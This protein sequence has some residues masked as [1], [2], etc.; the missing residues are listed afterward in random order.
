MSI[1]ERRSDPRTLMIASVVGGWLVGLFLPTDVFQLGL[2]LV[3][4]LFELH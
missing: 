2:M 4:L 3:G 1:A